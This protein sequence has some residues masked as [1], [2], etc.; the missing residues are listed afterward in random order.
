VTFVN[1]NKM[2]TAKKFN[3]LNTTMR[4][5]ARQHA[6][7]HNHGAWMLPPGMACNLQDY[8]EI[9]KC[10]DVSDA[11]AAYLEAKRIGQQMTAVPQIARL[12]AAKRSYMTRILDSARAHIITAARYD[13]IDVI[14]T[15]MTQYIQSFEQRK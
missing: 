13:S 4:Q 15:H 14:L 6:D 10:F 5:A 2:P 12:D 11:N 1:I 9:N 3:E 8:S 7:L